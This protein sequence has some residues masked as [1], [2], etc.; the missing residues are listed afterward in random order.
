MTRSIRLIRRGA[1]GSEGLLRT[2]ALDR[3][4][5]PTGILLPTDWRCCSGHRLFLRRSPF[6]SGFGPGC[7]DDFTFVMVGLIGMQ[8]LNAGL[9]A[10]SN[11]IDQAVTR[12]WFEMILVEPV[13]W[14]FL[15]FAM[16]QWPIANALFATAVISGFA[17]LLGATITVSGIPL[18][19]IVGALGVTVG[20]AIGGLAAV[21][22]STR[23]AR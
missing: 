19:I 5:V 13:P 1:E 11:E 8:M 21:R 10:L 2:W 17:L 12:G 20:L 4:E 18:A 23:E 15:P 16:A 14:H 6:R 9:R 3:D 22:E 7:G